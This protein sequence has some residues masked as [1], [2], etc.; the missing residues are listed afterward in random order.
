MLDQQED[1]DYIWVVENVTEPDLSPG[2][3]EKSG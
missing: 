1:L 3:R 2:T